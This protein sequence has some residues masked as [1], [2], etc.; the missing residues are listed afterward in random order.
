MSQSLFETF[1]KRSWRTSEELKLLISSLL[2]NCSESG[3]VLSEVLPKLLRAKFSQSFEFRSVQ[4]RSGENSLEFNASKTTPPSFKFSNLIENHLR[5]LRFKF[6]STFEA[7]SLDCRL[8][9]L[10]KPGK[11]QET[12]FHRNTETKTN[13]INLFSTSTRLK[14]FSNWH[15]TYQI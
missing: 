6:L 11:C 13:I 5:E 4:K 8:T 14:L 2:Q 7:I 15:L 3:S 10:T 12:R 1:Q 9:H